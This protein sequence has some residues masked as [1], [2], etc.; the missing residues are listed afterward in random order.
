MSAQETIKKVE[1]NRKEAL[2]SFVVTIVFG[3]LAVVA[4]LVLLLYGGL[5]PGLDEISKDVAIV[6]GLLFFFLSALVFLPHALTITKRYKRESLAILM[7]YLTP[8]NYQDFVY[9]TDY[10][11]PHLN[12]VFRH[13]LSVRDNR[14]ETSYFEGRLPGAK[15]FSFAYSYIRDDRLSRGEILGRYVEFV[16]PHT[17][18]FEMIM[19]DRRSPSYFKKKRLLIRLKSDS[20]SF[21]AVHDVTA[22]KEVEGMNLLSMKMIEAIEAINDDYGVKLSARFKANKVSV[23]F[24]D[25]R[26][27]YLLSIDN[28]FDAKAFAALQEEVLLVYRAYQALN[29]DSSFYSI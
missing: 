3:S 20:A 1:Q 16:L 14:D 27:R 9:K 17:F 21:D 6:I 4:S 23:Y 5:E 8:K 15:F 18:P 10:N 24:D 11:T 28:V 22:N 19:K 26:S 29:L 2:S 7:P 13:V 12:Q 25:Y